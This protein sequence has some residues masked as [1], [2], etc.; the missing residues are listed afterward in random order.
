MRKI[1]IAQ[2][3]TSINSHG[4]T[5]FK[6]LRDQTDV[7]EVVGYAFPEKEGER[8]PEQLSF[9]EGYPELTVEEILKNPE[10]EA[11]TIETEEQLDW[12]LDGE[13][14][15]GKPLVQVQCLH[16]AVQIIRKEESV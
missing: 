10:I 3:G 7:F 1:K 4:R 2:I 8:F 14:E 9:F 15:H 6:S 16:H 5:I 13:C 12:T 11:V